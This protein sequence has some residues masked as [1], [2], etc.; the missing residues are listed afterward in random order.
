VRILVLNP[1]SATLKATVVD[2]PD[3]AAR[4]ERSVDWSADARPIEREA[5]VADAIAAMERAGIGLDKVDAVG[6]RVVHG[7]E[8]FTAPTLID[9]EVVAAID[10]LQDLAPVHNPLAAATIRAVRTLMPDVPHVAAFDTA[11]HAG[12]PETARRYPVP[13]EWSERYGIRRYGFH[14][15][16]VEWSVGRAAELLERPIRSL[17]MVVAHLGGGSSATAVEGGRSVATSMGLTPLE[18]LMMA[19]RAGSI[20]PGIV[21]HMARHGVSL[22]EIERGLEHGS[23]L[24]A[25]GGTSDMRRLLERETHDGHA[26]LAIGMFVDRAAAGIAGAATALG[27]FD[28]LVFTGGIGEG[29]ASVRARICGRLTSLG[30]TE[31]IADHAAKPKARVEDA[32]VNSNLS[33]AV[34]RVVAR[35]DLVIADAALAL[36]KA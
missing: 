10:D 20:D 19:T 5:A 13:V 25:V 14:G 32:I 27:S 3:R 2:P 28:A 34:L 30:V 23:G 18:G 12:L 31:T 4:F 7:G 36:L 6:Y 35:E 15:L 22:D 17:G 16:S 21:F 9:D 11:F 8:H 29:A 26:A 24:L 33:P 1:G